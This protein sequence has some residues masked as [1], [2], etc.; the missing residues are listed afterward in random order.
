MA[1]TTHPVGVSLV[2][3]GRDAARTGR[4]AALRKAAGLSQSELA[5]ALARSAS[6][7]SRWEAGQRLPSHE[8][9]RSYAMVLRG[10]AEDLAGLEG[11]A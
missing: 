3:E 4:G 9:A 11:G 5:G 1:A 10:I 6:C 2:I 7:V 8:A